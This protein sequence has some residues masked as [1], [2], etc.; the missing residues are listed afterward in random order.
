MT[1]S[2]LSIWNCS[3]LCHLTVKVLPGLKF[4]SS[5]DL[6]IIQW[7]YTSDFSI[8]LPKKKK[9]ISIFFY[10]SLYHI[11]IL[12]YTKH[13]SAY[14]RLTLLL[15]FLQNLKDMYLRNKMETSCRLILNSK[16]THTTSRARFE[17]ETWFELPCLRT[18]NWPTYHT[19]DE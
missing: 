6:E 19:M 13:Y 9:I 8:G 2:L 4:G 16:F 3:W 18:C 14:S 10:F 17:C 12:M 1:Y 5:K 7:K 11:H 15:Y